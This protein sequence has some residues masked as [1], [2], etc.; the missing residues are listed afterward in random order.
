MILLRL[1]KSSR[2]GGMAVVMLLA[3]GLFMSCFIQQK[4]VAGTFAM[5]FYNL[6]FGSIHMVPFVN[7]LIALVITILL[8]Y[9]LIRV[10]VRFVLLDF[11]S[12][13]PAVFFILFTMAL[14][15][16]RQVTPV[17]VGSVFYLLCFSILFDVQDEKPDTIKIFIAGLMLALGSMF[18]LKLIWFLP[19]FWISLATMRTVNWREMLF[20]VIALALMA[21]FLFTWYWGVLDDAAAF[22]NLISQNLA[23]EGSFQPSHYSIHIYYGFLLMLV[24]VA[25]I[26]M[27][28]RFQT[29]KTA[30]QKIYQ[31]LFYMFLSGILFFAFIARFDPS[32]LI[33]IAIPVAYILSGFFHRKKNH[34]FH[35]LILWVVLGLLV[36]VQFTV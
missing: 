25:S 23:F 11:R 28:K 19:F 36:Y 29:R 17:L 14:P 5:P 31:V 32:T 15:A 34:W 35:E 30:V 33:F 27:I 8:G 13:M 3:L 21:L 2:T 10:G 22:N 18:Y 20:P 16:T 6:I 4:E 26:Y 1:L 7:R 9:M 12:F 24:V